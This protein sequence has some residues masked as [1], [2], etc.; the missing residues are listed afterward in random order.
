MFGPAPVRWVIET[1]SLAEVEGSGKEA[2]KDGAISR[3]DCSG[4]TCSFYLM[5]SPP[6]G[7]NEYGSKSTISHLTKSWE[8]YFV[9]ENRFLR[10][11]RCAVLGIL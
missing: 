5:T 6:N 10:E 4:A 2:G 8:N 7:R 3:A 9:R 11:K 1:L